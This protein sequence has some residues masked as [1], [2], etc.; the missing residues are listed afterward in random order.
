[1]CL[2]MTRP[3]HKYHRLYSRRRIENVHGEYRAIVAKLGGAIW[4]AAT[5]VMAIAALDTKMP[6]DCALGG[7]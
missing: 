2:N 7:G 3:R 4:L 6:V 1:M 5:A